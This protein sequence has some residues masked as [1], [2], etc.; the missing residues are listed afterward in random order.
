MAR[1]LERQDP[2]QRAAELGF[3]VLERIENRV[4]TEQG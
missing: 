2:D 1:S 3:K 4:S